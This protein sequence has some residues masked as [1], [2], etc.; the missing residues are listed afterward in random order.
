M[1]PIII[2][3]GDD[4]ERIEMNPVTLATLHSIIE[5]NDKIVAMNARIVDA[6]A[7]PVYVIKREDPSATP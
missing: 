6:L 3:H 1:Q 5:Q 4:V 7:L 2:E